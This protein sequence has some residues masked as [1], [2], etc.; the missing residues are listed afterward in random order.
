MSDDSSVRMYMNRFYWVLL[1]FTGFYL[2]LLGFYWD[3][4]GI[5]P[6]ETG[7]QEAAAY[8]T[9]D[10]PL[11]IERISRPFPLRQKELVRRNCT[12]FFT[13]F[14]SSERIMARVL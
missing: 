6:L 10:L 12:L 13:E 3:F 8:K 7:F 9:N 1:G 2:V 11:F 5:L 14:Y 4:T